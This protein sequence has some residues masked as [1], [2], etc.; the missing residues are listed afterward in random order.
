MLAGRLRVDRLGFLNIVLC[1]TYP[2]HLVNIQQDPG[3]IRLHELRQAEPGVGEGEAAGHEGQHG[4]AG[5][6]HHV[7]TARSLL[8][9]EDATLLHGVVQ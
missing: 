7:D 2:G 6:Q 8:V 3:R 9:T 5:A 4:E 1:P